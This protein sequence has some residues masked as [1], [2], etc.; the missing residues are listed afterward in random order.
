MRHSVL[1]EKLAEQVFK[2]LDIFR[3]KFYEPQF[4]HLLL[5]KETLTS[6][7][8]TSALAIKENITIQ[9]Q[10]EIKKKKKRTDILLVPNLRKKQSVFFHL[11]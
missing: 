4:L 8:V 3:R 10:N 11:V 7:T 5:P 2:T 1:W 6:I 9:S